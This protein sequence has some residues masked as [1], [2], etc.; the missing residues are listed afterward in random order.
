MFNMF[1]PRT[2]NFTHLSLFKWDF[3]MS[4]STHS[5]NLDL[6]FMSHKVKTL[7]FKNYYYY[8]FIL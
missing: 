2:V 7:N 5:I 6:G 4:Y 3:T 8:F 1:A